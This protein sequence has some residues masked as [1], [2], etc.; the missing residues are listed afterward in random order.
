MSP[1]GVGGPDPMKIVTRVSTNMEAGNW[2]AACDDLADLGRLGQPVPLV[3]GKNV[4]V[5]I[6]PIVRSKM[7]PFYEHLRG[8]RKSWV[9]VSYGRTTNVRNDPPVM[10]VPVRATYDYA[11]ITQQEREVILHNWS[12]ESGTPRTW[13]EFVQEMKRRDKDRAR[14]DD[15]P[16]WTFAWLDERW[17]LYIGPPFK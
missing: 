6:P 5:Q 3:P 9:N 12:K 14:L 1:L 13:P 17:R 16:T 15:W 11:R 10:S 8:L 4:P 2:S 7:R